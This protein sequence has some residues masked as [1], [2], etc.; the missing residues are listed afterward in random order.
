MI[1]NPEVQSKAQEELDKVVGPNRLPEFSDEPELPYIR[2]ICKES[3]RWQP[4]VPLGVPHVSI[5]DDEYRGMFIPKGST[6]L[7]NQ[8]SVYRQPVL[9]LTTLNLLYEGTCFEM[10]RISA[11]EQTNS[12]RSDFSRLIGRRSLQPLDSEE[13]KPSPVITNSHFSYGT[14]KPS[15]SALEDIWQT[16]PSSS[17]LALFCIRSESKGPRT[18]WAV[19]FQSPQSSHPL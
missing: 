18:R 5:R 4:A 12:D 10:R 3:L 2:A 6:I 8:W 13:G 15:E 1:L 9:H 11:P 7:I 14:P 17:S 19:K 16:I